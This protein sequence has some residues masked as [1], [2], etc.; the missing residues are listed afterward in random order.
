MLVRFSYT[1]K[2]PHVPCH[3]KIK[4]I[5]ESVYAPSKYLHLLCKFVDQQ[6]LN[7]TDDS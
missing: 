3:V 4:I 6:H 2:S 7:K 5:S 1:E